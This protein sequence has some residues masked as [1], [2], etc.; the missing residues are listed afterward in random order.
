[1]DLSTDAGSV[2]YRSLL[3]TNRGFTIERNAV[4]GGRRECDKKTFSIGVS[5]TR[6]V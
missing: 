3:R 6:S 1:M 5:I 2:R 4:D